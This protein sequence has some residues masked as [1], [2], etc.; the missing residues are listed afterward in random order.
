MA[1]LPSEN[2]DQVWSSIMSE[3]SALHTIIPL[4]DLQLKQLLVLIDQ[5]L[6][7]AE[8]SIVQALPAGDG[9]TWLIAHPAIGR[10]L[11]LNVLQKRKE[12]L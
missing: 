10:S 1:Q 12:V 3:L 2:I 8:V 11:M 7:D 6:E 9:K 5:E 4:S